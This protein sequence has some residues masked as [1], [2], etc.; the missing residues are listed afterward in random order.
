M[1]DFCPVTA[2]CLHR[3]LK[4]FGH[5][6]ARHARAQLPGNHITREV[7][8]NGGQIHPTPTNDFQVREVRLPHLIDGRG[9]I[10]KLTGGRHDN[11]GRTGDQVVRLQ[12]P[13]DRAFGYEVAVRVGEGHGQLARA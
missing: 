5:V 9:L 11:E 10:F 4:S 6:T 1:N 8:Q 7:I 3:K 13:V 2:R 12:K